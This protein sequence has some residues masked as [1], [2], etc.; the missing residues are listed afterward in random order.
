MSTKNN[1]SKKKTALQQRRYKYQ[2]TKAGMDVIALY[3]QLSMLLS[4]RFTYMAGTF[5]LKKM[6][7]I[8]TE[9][10]THTYIGIVM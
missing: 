6:D 9:T 8:G 10:N 2:P 3:L 7:T 5:E 1:S 4:S